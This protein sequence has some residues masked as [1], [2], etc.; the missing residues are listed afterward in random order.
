MQ[1]LINDLL[2]YSRM[3]TKGRE[4][5]DCDCETVLDLALANLKLAIQES[6]ATV[7]RNPLPKVKGDS[8]QLLQLFQNLISNAIKFR[9]EKAPVIHISAGQEGASWHFTVSDNGIGLDMKYAD[10]IFV[11]FQRLHTKESYPGSGIGLSLCKKIVERHGGRLWVES[12]TGAGSSFNFTIPVRAA[13]R[14][15]RT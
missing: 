7:H 6:G 8:S 3:E 2:L 14:G 12:T 4:F 1:E 9:G 15:G 13:M 11:I 10:R 5:Q